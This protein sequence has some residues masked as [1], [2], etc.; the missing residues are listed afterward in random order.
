[1]ADTVSGSTKLWSHSILKSRRAKSPFPRLTTSQRPEIHSAHE[2]YSTKS[3]IYHDC[4]A[5]YCWLLSRH[6]ATCSRTSMKVHT[7]AILE[8]ELSLLISARK[9]KDSRWLVGSA[10]QP[11]K[12]LEAAATGLHPLRCWGTVRKVVRGDRWQG[13]SCVPRTISSHWSN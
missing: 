10:R 1:M 13:S 7:I 6:S 12:L 8:T 4:Q 11:N 2:A 9:S 5:C 3:L